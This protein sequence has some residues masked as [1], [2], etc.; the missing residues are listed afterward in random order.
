MTMAESHASTSI[1]ESIL[2]PGR[3][4]AYIAKEFGPE[5]FEK[6]IRGRPGKV[7]PEYWNRAIEKA[8]GNLS[9]KR[10]LVEGRTLAKMGRERARG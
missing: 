3:S 8:D 5:A 7:R 4:R 2:H 10:A 9:L 6:G 1:R